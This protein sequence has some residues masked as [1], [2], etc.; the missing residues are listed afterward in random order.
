M[1]KESALFKK[2]VLIISITLIL[3][4]FAGCMFIAPNPGQNTGQMG[5]VY[6]NIS[7]GNWYYYIYLDSYSNYLGTTDIYGQ[8]TKAFYNIPIGYH[9]FYAEDVDGWYS[10]QKTQYIQPGSNIVNIQ[11]YFNY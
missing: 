5:T 8:K 3:G 10:G 9:T 1:I 7:N 4:L 6:I 2:S 11:V